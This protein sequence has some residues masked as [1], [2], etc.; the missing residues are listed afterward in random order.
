MSF[1]GRKLVYGS[2]FAFKYAL[3][4]HNSTTTTTQGDAMAGGWRSSLALV[5]KEH[6]G[7]KATDGTKSSGDHATDDDAGDCR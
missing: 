3:D 1:D 7:I 2:K 4:A 5:L 6:N